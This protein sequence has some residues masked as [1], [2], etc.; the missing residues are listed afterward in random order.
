MNRWLFSVSICNKCEER[1]G[2]GVLDS[3]TNKLKERNSGDDE[4]YPILVHQSAVYAW[5][6]S[7]RALSYAE[8]P[9][10][11]VFRTYWNGKASFITIEVTQPRKEEE[12]STNGAIRPL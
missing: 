10:R 11:T 7:H 9:D 12:P 4:A 8:L 1:F 3:L 5:E 2:T 6:D